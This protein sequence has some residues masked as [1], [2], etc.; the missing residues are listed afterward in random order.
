M[1]L[2]TSVLENTRSLTP[3]R[4]SRS[5]RIESGAIEALRRHTDTEI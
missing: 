5:S 2:L 1:T 3:G 4:K